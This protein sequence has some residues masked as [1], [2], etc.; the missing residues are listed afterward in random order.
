MNLNVWRGCYRGIGR[1]NAVIANVPDISMDENLKN[2]FIGEAKF[3]R[4]FYYDRMNEVFK[5]VPLILDPPDINEHIN[6]PRDSYENVVEAILKDLT[7]AAAV[8]PVSY[9]SSD[10]GRATKGAALSLKARVL[11]QNHRYSE[12]ITTINEVFNLNH[13]ELFPHYNGLFR[14][15]NEG[16][17]EIIFDVRFKAPEVTNSYDII[18]AQYST[19]APLQNLVDDY[20]MIDGKSIQDSELYDENNPYVNRDPRFAQSI[21]YLGV[22]WRSRVAT[23]FDLHQTGYSFR[24]FT[25]YN[26]TT[27]GTLSNSETN[28]IVIRYADVL[29]MYAEA[30]NELEG[31]VQGVYDA[32]NEVRNRPSVEMPDIPAGLTKE[33]MREAVRLER[34]IE[35]AG[36]SSYFFD[37]R[38]WGIIDEVMPGPIYNYE[39]EIIE[40]REFN[41]ARDILFPIPYTEIDLNPALQQNPGY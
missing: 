8:L 39:R 12:V 41:P 28:F 11:L 38:R 33:Q 2:R 4:A 27:E 31:P 24:K 3:L 37:I 15:I 26:A 34:R 22:P 36:E 25:E 17:S 35:L 18:L 23:E 5:G 6:L 1:C 20:Q 9:P 40:T 7:E 30:L 16:N 32:I 19:Q 21:L 10:D 13:Y 29:L 14:K